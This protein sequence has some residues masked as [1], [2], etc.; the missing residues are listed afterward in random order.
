MSSELNATEKKCQVIINKGTGAGGANTN[1][2]GKKFEDKTNNQNR[3]LEMGYIKNSYTK[4]KKTNDFYLVKTFEDKTIVFVL[5]N[6]LKTYMKYKYNIDMF[7]CPDEAYIIEY[8]SGK[9][10]I[11]II[12]KKEQN[13]EGSVETKLWAGPSL[14]REYE[15]ILDNE[16]EVHY[17]FSVNNFLKKK[18]TSNN[19]KY[20]ILNTILQENN[21]V[22]FF[23]DDENY[24]KT[25]D[26]WFNN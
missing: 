24:F 18:L 16:F 4:S 12:E 26:I 22:V 5:Q 9:K 17:G 7:R 14:K 1:F 21:I 2:Y 20:T 19:K 8:T 15:L 11:K 13:V 6:G 10:V 3:L 23:G 25:I